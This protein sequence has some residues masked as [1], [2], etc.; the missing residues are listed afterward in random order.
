MFQ[1]L[2]RCRPVIAG[3]IEHAW[4]QNEEERES[5]VESSSE[6]RNPAD[7][8]LW[9]SVSDGSVTFKQFL[10][11]AGAWVEDPDPDGTF[12]AKWEGDRPPQPDYVTDA[13]DWPLTPG[14]S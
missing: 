5:R 6:K 2:M 1:T 10:R 14:A 13:A 11:T 7:F 4:K 3:T 9:K 8:A 12:I